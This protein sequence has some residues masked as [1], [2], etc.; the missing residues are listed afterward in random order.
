MFGYQLMKAE[1]ENN[2]NDLIDNTLH[3]IF[4]ASFDYRTAEEGR[5]KHS[6]FDDLCWYIWT[7][8]ATVQWIKALSKANPGKL[9]AYVLKGG[10]STDD[11]I[12]SVT[13]YLTRY[14]NLK[15]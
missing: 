13:S 3:Q 9:L 4:L 10:Q 15:Y 7:G 2:M 12:R 11:R 8:R 1:K 5:A 6:V 14:C